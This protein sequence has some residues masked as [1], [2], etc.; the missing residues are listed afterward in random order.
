MLKKYAL[1]P[2]IIA[3]STQ[4]AGGVSIGAYATFNATHYCGDDPQHVARN[5]QL[6]CEEL[7]IPTSHLIVPHQVHDTRS[8]EINTIFLSS[9]LEKQSELLEGVDAV[10]T[11]EKGVCVC[12]STADCIPVLLYHA[13]AEVRAKGEYVGIREMRKHAAWYTAGYP[14]SARLREGINNI[15]SIEDMKDLL[16]KYRGGSTANPYDS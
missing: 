15:Q 5:K 13:E 10:Y 3:F 6:L 12:V 2:D 1:S 14:G 8:L 4:R 11:T 9:H 16:D 7:G